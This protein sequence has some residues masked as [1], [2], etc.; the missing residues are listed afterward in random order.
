MRAH[1]VVLGGRLVAMVQFTRAP[2]LVQVAAHVQAP[3]TVVSK[4]AM[5]RRHTQSSARKLWVSTA[6]L[7]SVPALSGNPCI[8]SQA[9]GVAKELCALH[10]EHRLQEPP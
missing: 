10:A 7:N 2:V 6:C 4:K 1:Q 8:A 3:H 9:W 5:Y